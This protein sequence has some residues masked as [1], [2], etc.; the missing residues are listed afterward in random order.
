MELNADLGESWYERQIGDDAAL[1]PYLDACNVACGFHGGDALTMQRTIDL[2]LE[3]GVSIGAHPSFPDRKHFGR[4]PRQPA[5]DQLR[6][7]LVYQVAALQGMVQA[8]GS[9][10]HHLKLHGALYHYA[11]RETAAAEALVSVMKALE[12]PIL[13]GPPNGALKEVATAANL[14]FYAEGF[15][16]RRYEDNLDLRSR[17]HADAAIESVEEAVEQVRLL[18]DGRVRTVN[19]EVRTITVDTMCVHGDHPGAADKARAIR[20]A[21][22]A[23]LLRG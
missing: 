20:R 23:T 19:G 11:N 16:D 17:H 8:A 1:M 7:W 4:S 10:L 15:V 18:L 3:H 13:Y 5:T 21:L 12:V 2:A 6:A 14:L 9:R 22:D